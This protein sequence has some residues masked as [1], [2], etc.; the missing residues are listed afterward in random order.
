MNFDTTLARFDLKVNDFGQEIAIVTEVYSNNIFDIIGCSSIEYWIIQRKPYVKRKQ[1]CNMLAKLGINNLYGYFNTTYGLTL[2]DA[3]WIKPDNQSKLTWEKVNLY[4]NKFNK[5]VAHFAFDGSGVVSKTTSPEYSTDGALAK[6][7][8]RYNNQV[9]L[10]KRGSEGASNCG[11]EPYSEV[12]A[13]Q[14]L[15]AIKRYTNYV[16]YDGIIYHNKETSRCPIFTSE[17][18][19]FRTQAM[20]YSPRTFEE[21]FKVQMESPYANDFRFMYVFDALILNEDRHLNNY[22]YLIDNRSGIICGFAPLFDHGLGLLAYYPF[23]KS[24]FSD[25]FIYAD[26]RKMSCDADFVA[27][28][29]KCITPEIRSML[30]NLRGFKLKP[31]FNDSESATNSLSKVIQRQIIKILA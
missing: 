5:A 4:Q 6:C 24:N 29:K 30:I 17:S 9:Y 12:Y 8:H 27:V 16:H 18:I 10:Y 11:R 26:S 2:T 31:V 15:D 13:T 1:I 20:I 7:W 25:I 21:L 22:G 28:A 23:S 3:L 14:L 19:G